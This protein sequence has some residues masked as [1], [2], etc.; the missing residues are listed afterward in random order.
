[1][2]LENRAASANAAAPDQRSGIDAYPSEASLTGSLPGSPDGYANNIFHTIS[3]M[4]DTRLPDAFESAPSLSLDDLDDY[5]QVT[6]TGE[7]DWVIFLKP[8]TLTGSLLC[9]CMLAK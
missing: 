5:Q 6:G 3:D 4:A 7:R 1:M 9:S 8:L 2:A